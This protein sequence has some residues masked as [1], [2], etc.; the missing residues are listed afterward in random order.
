MRRE[1]KKMVG[2]QR[3]THSQ[4]HGQDSLIWRVNPPKNEDGLQGKK[5]LSLLMLSLNLLAFLFH[6]AMAW[7]ERPGSA[8]AHQRRPLQ[9]IIRWRSSAWKFFSRPTPPETIS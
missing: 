4:K 3:P 5:Y 2:Q 1:T 8:T 9:P 7:T 6:T